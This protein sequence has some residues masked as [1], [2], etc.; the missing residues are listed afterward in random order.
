MIQY[1]HQICTTLSEYKCMGRFCFLNFTQN[2]VLTMTYCSVK[3]CKCT[4]SCENII[5][6]T[7]KEQWIAI[8]KWKTNSPSRICSRHFEKQCYSSQY[9]FELFVFK[10]SFKSVFEICVAIKLLYSA[11]H[12]PEK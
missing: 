1:K 5:L 4:S 2:S 7:I 11:S 8:I 10:F 12:F 3:D 9:L 6:H